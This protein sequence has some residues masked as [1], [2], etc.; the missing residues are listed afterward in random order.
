MKICTVIV[1][2]NPDECN[3]N[4]ILSYSNLVER[5]YIVDNSNN[6]N[7]QLALKIDNATY[8]P[9]LDN[10]GIAYA[11]NRG[12][13]KAL[14]D[15]FDWCMTMDQDSFWDE[16]QLRDYIGKCEMGKSLN[17]ISFAPSL[18]KAGGSKLGDLKRK[19]FHKKEI[20]P[21]CQT[22]ITN[23]VITSGNIINLKT[24]KLIGCFYEP[25]FIDEVDYEFCFRLLR[26]NYNIIYFDSVL[27]QHTIGSGKKTILPMEDSHSGIRLFYISRNILWMTKNY[28]EYT[29]GYK[30]HLC[31]III[32]NVLHLNIKNQFYILKGI[33]AFYKNKMGKFTY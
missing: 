26:N 7:S 27:M 24:W 15:G 12:C 31:K 25:L 6:D 17:N 33:Q 21:S 20:I 19:L 32:T 30:K 2:Y 11:L 28:P 5:C 9:N 29:N 18:P 4:N 14:D 1:W 10:L 23:G 3:V 22:L 13:Q 8:L 16:P